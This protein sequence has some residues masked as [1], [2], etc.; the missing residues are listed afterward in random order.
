MPSKIGMKKKVPS[1]IMK[2]VMHLWNPEM[3]FLINNYIIA[4]FF[5]ATFSAQVHYELF[6]GYP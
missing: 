4:Y 3:G 6:H 1:S 2:F 5:P